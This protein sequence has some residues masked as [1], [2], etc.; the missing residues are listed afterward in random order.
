[1]IYICADDYG[2]A[3]SASA[4]ILECVEHGA[5]NKVSVFPNSNIRYEKE[6]ENVSL[7]LH[8][9][10][11]EGQSM[12]PP[13]EV[14]MLVTDNGYFKYSFIGLF[15]LSV[16]GKR[17]EFENQL[18]NEIKA[19]LKFWKSCIAPD[20]PVL[21][22]SHQHTHMIPLIFKVLMHVISDEEIKVRYLRIPAEPVMPYLK[23]P[24][25]YHTYKPVN[26]I[27]QWLLKLFELI[28]RDEYKRSGI[29]TAYFMGILFSG[30]MNKERVEKVLPHYYKLSEK[31]N[32]DVEIL[33]HPGYIEAEEKLLDAR[34][35]GFERFYFSKGRK[36][37]YDTVMN[38]NK[39]ERRV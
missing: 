36:I 27:K 24:S 31:H 39:K 18:Y 37:E 28:N 15:L 19:Q 8:I 4:H 38:Y 22:D 23:T 14:S 12:A 33:F 17:K 35:K 25:L 3:K 26:I 5:L 20:E 30:M 34:K 10:L 13:E 9:N 1:M 16:S 7:S 32:M 29:P 11:V 6:S 2:V 21:I